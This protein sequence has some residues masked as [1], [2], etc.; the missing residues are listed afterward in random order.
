M[1]PVTEADELAILNITLSTKSK[2]RLKIA[3]IKKTLIKTP[4]YR[5]AK[6]KSETKI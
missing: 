5:A 6:N 4:A 1:L 3:L 2:S